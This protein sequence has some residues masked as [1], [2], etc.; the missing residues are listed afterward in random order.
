MNSR[1]HITVNS[2]RED[3]TEIPNAQ[4]SEHK[5][6]MPTSATTTPNPGQKMRSF[7][8]D[9]SKVQIKQQGEGDADRIGTLWQFNKVL[10]IYEAIGCSSVSIDTD[11]K[12]DSLQHERNQQPSEEMKQPAGLEYPLFIY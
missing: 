12:Y 4:L 7:R 2:A 8:I 5:A 10:G 3:P 6:A 9:F 1:V 11:C